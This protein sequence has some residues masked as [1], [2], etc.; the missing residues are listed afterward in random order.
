[1]R[2]RHTVAH[3]EQIRSRNDRCRCNSVLCEK[4]DKLFLIASGLQSRSR[5]RPT[6]RQKWFRVGHF[7]D[8]DLLDALYQVCKHCMH[9]RNCSTPL[10]NIQSDA[11]ACRI[12]QTESLPH[13]LFQLDIHLAIINRGALLYRLCPRPCLQD[14]LAGCFDLASELSNQSQTLHANKGGPRS[15]TTSLSIVGMLAA[16]LKSTGNQS[17]KTF[18]ELALPFTR[19]WLPHSPTEF[20]AKRWLLFVPGKSVPI[21][22]NRCNIQICPGQDYIWQA[23]QYI[24]PVDNIQNEQ[25]HPIEGETKLRNAHSFLCSC[26]TLHHAQ[27]VTTS[28]GSLRKQRNHK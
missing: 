15:V 23:A 18:N 20:L 9:A 16:S 25:K 12:H 5:V 8:A 4:T 27:P 19:P 28:I 21:V 13:F 11:D 17:G 22:C 7:D 26:V 24:E 14:L 6:K 2:Q 1:V 3:Q 10:L